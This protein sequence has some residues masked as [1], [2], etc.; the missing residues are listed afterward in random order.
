MSYSLVILDLIRKIKNK[1]TRD[2]S[3]YKNPID[4]IPID[5]IQSLLDR[6][7]Y[8]SAEIRLNIIE[9]HGYSV[10]KIKGYEANKT[11]KRRIEIPL[12]YNSITNPN[13]FK[14]IKI[15]QLILNVSS[16]PNNEEEDSLKT[17]AMLIS[18]YIGDQLYNLSLFRSKNSI[19][20]IRNEL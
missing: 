3:S 17:L 6:L 7:H 10:K 19:K 8:T 9:I 15:G 14:I 2:I 13:K 5:I 11:P 18:E 16:V 1:K 20:K 12:E 4:F